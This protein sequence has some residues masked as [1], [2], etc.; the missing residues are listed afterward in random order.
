MSLWHFHSNATMQT[1]TLLWKWSVLYKEEF[2]N[3]LGQLF[4]RTCRVRTCVI[5]LVTVI[6]SCVLKRKQIGRVTSG[7]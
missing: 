1:E 6:N 5:E 3:E 2:W 4:E 7:V